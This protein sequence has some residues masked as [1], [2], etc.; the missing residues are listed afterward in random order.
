MLTAYHV[1]TTTWFC[2]SIPRFLRGYQL[3]HA[4][5]EFAS[6]TTTS[7]PYVSIYKCE[8]ILK[9]RTDQVSRVH[10]RGDLDTA[11]CQNATRLVEIQ[12]LV[13]GGG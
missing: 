10:R 12:L 11:L 9:T 7:F 4:S 2:N 6:G 13:R 5:P 1:A 8:V 3:C